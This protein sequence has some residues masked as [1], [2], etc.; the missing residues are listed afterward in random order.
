MKRSDIQALRGFAVLAVLLYHLQIGRLKGGFLGVDIFFVISGFVITQRLARGEGSVRVQILDFYQRRA[1][2]ILPASLLVIALTALAMRF[3]LAPLAF[4]RFGL[5]G[6]ATTLFA[7]NIRFTMQGNDYLNQSMSPT[8]FLHYWSL[9]VEE[10][11]YL[12]W[13]LLFLFFFKTR[14]KMIFPFALITTGFA[15]WYTH[16]S[17]VNSFYLPYSRA[18]EFL[19]GILIAI[20]TPEISWGYR[21]RNGLATLGWIGVT[22]SVLMIGSDQ[23]VPGLTTLIPVVS[24]MAI[25]WSNAQVPWEKLLERLGDYSYAIYLVHWPLIVIALSRYQKLSVIADLII[26]TQT[27]LLGYLISN[28]VERPLR[29]NKKF[30]IGLPAWGASVFAVAAILFGATSY[31]APQVSTAKSLIDLREPVI[32]SDKCHLDFGVSQPKSECLFGDV[33][34]STLVVLAGDSHAAQWFSG[35]NAVAL[36]EHWKLLSLTKSSCPAAL[37]PTKRNGVAD[38]SCE[39]WQRYLVKRINELHPSKVLIT[40]FSEY[41]YPLVQPGDY[42]SLYLKDQSAL[43]SALKIV[44]STIYYIEDTPRP[45]QSIPDCISKNLKNL[46]ICDFVLN[47][48]AATLALRD[49]LPKLGVHFLN[50]NKTLCP[51]NR[52]LAIYSGKSAYRDASHISVNTSLALTS[53]LQTALMK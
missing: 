28:Y 31:A 41:N 47:R 34:S 4:K 26:A 12:I 16:A 21:A 33:R 46:A 27:I 19:A 38:A 10:Q 9:G 5:D 53:V 35:L 32:Y 6:I 3:Y 23:P 13:P 39:Q 43:I 15:I 24:A 8:P 29:F 49:G 45:N 1:K 40:A 37:M 11:F 36:K 48:S 20:V 42:S 25:L 44:P 30:A 14:K 17:P 52:C 51:T 50:F 2:R 7:G 22:A 18:W